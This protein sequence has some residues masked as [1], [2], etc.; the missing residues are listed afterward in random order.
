MFH[1]NIFV[2]EKFLLEMVLVQ[3]SVVTSDKRET[4]LHQKAQIFNLTQF[5]SAN[6]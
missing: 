6:I 3:D 4:D 5:C 1:G 2:T